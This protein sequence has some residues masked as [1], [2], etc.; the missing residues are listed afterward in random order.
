MYSDLSK[1]RLWKRAYYIVVLSLE[2]GVV[3]TPGAFFADKGQ[4]NQLWDWG[5][6]T[7]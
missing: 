7:K 4:Q 2:N 3:Y 5:M 6:D 1:C